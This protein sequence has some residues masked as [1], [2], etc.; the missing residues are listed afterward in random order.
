VGSREN[1]NEGDFYPFVHPSVNNSETFGG[2]EGA[3]ADSLTAGK[4]A[5]I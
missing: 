5:K 2:S 4:Q 1:T 3:A